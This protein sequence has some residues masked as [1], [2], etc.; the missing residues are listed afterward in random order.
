MSD[1][2]VNFEADVTVPDCVVTEIVPVVAPAGTGTLKDVPSGAALE[3]K[4]FALV[5]LN[6]TEVTPVKALP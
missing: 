4:R 1:P 3:S 2:T 6:F 5:P